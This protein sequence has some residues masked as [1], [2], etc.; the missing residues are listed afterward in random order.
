MNTKRKNTEKPRIL[1]SCYDNTSREGET[2]ISHH[3]LSY[4]ISGT[5]DIRIGNK[6]FNFKDGDI[7]FFRKN[8]LASFIKHPVNGEFKSISIYF[9]EA[10]LR[11]FSAENNLT[12]SALYKNESVQLLKPSAYL[13]K[14]LDSLSPYIDG[15]G[16]NNEKLSLLKVREAIMILLETNPLLK[17]I[18]FDFSEPGK[19]DL[20]A[21]MNEHYRHNQELNH[22]A[23]LTGR[24]L[25]TFK[26]DF[27]QIFKITPNRWLLQKRLEHA[28]YLIKEKGMK[29]S[30]V[31]LDV[32]FTDLSHFSFA[33]KKAYKISPSKLLDIKNDK[34]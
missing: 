29:P 21:F 20:E 17:N 2:F 33:F 10:T 7:R 5:Q 28:H 32:G 31:Y 3:V 22:F 13:V 11:D 12:A 19:I 8:Q 16:V 1:Y 25:S 30:E 18:L 23:F 6:T 24:S 9:D 15:T 26:R 4:I 27:E 34:K 14:Y